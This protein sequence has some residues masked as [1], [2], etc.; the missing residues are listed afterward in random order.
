MADSPQDNSA[1]PVTEETIV[2]V[3]RTVFD[4]EIPVSIYDLG[5]IYNIQVE[6]SEV[7]VRMTLTTPACPVAGTLPGQV[8]TRIKA[9][10][11]VNDA[12]VE[13]VW[14]PPWTPEKMSEAAKLQLNMDISSP[15]PNPPSFFNVNP[16][17][18]G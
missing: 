4:P 1:A 14:D 2:E 12:T 6:N 18:P 3:L 13:L 11:G 5:M 10:E 17:R 8:E 16:P 7:P 15:P 9:I